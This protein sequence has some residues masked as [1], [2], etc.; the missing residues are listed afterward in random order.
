MSERKEVSFQQ[1]MSLVIHFNCLFQMD[2]TLKKKWMFIEST[3][4]YIYIGY[5]MGLFGLFRKV[6]LCEL[7]KREYLSPSR[8]AI[9][10]TK[11]FGE[12]CTNELILKHLKNE[13]EP[14]FKL[15]SYWD[16][17]YPVSFEGDSY[18]NR[19]ARFFGFG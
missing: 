5:R 8:G 14:Q 1:T 2:S 3:D 10:T 18:N 4:N 17:D 12:P 19:K 7:E 15:H 13:L 16:S 11:L 9:L 6:Q